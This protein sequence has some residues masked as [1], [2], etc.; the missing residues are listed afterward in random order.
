MVGAFSPVPN[1]FY[2][3]SYFSIYV[4]S[5]CLQPDLIHITEKTFKAIALE[6]PFILVAPSGSLEYLRS[7]GFQ[8]FD[9]VIDESYDQE[10]NDIRRIERVTKLLRDLNN[11]SFHERQQLQRAMLP[12]VEHNYNHFYNG[13]FEHILWDE[14]TSML[15]K[16]ENDFCIRFNQ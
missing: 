12:M 13:D 9:S 16:L 5:N 4:E 10:S 2:L 6:M 8:T 15:G 11:L 3:D 7:Y 1:E 14:F